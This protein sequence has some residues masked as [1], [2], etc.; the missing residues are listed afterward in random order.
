MIIEAV[1]VIAVA[2]A[3]YKHVGKA[4]VVADVQAAVAKAEQFVTASS[5]VASI[6]ADLKKY[7]G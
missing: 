4:K 1:A 3:I 7:I 2:V 5:V 6:K